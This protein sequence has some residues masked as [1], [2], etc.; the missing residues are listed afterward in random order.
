METINKNILMRRVLFLGLLFFSSCIGANKSIKT[1]DDLKSAE[2]LTHQQ[3]QTPVDSLNKWGKKELDIQYM[4]IKGDTLKFMSAGWFFYYPFGKYDA[5]DPIRSK[6]P[7]FKFK[8]EA[9]TAKYD[10]VKFYRMSF[11]DSFVKFL[12]NDDTGKMEIVYGKI[13]NDEIVLDNGFKIGL[14]KDLFFKYFFKNPAHL[15]NIKYVKIDSILEGMFYT[16]YFE[17]DT[18]S[19]I[20]IDTDYQ[21]YKF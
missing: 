4:E 16:F 12:K 17:N 3:A 20:T 8:I 15:E 9:D 11:K 2:V 1:E 7:F 13:I 21:L 14:N 5:M 18:I 10:P 19:S 6:Y